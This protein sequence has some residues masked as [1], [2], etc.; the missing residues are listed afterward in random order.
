MVIHEFCVKSV[1]IPPDKADAPLSVHADAVLPQ[2]VAFQFFQS[3]GRGHSQILQLKGVMDHLQLPL[4]C[5]QNA[6]WEAGNP[7]AVKQGLG[8]F[9]CEG[10]DHTASLIRFQS[11]PR[12]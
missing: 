9:V 5:P 3:V 4:R 8:M 10:F 6:V 11:N 2:P 12:L 7:D 1:S